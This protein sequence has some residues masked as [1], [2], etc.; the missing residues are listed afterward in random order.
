[1]K[2]NTSLAA[3]LA[4]V[5]IS[6]LHGFPMRYAPS[7][8]FSNFS[9]T[10]LVK[11]NGSPSGLSCS[12]GGMGGIGGGGGRAD[13]KQ[14]SYNKSEAFSCRIKSSITNEF[15]EAE[16][17]S[18]LRSD[19]KKDLNE[20]DQKITSAK[21]PTSSSF[22]FEY[23]EGEMRGRIEITGER[24]G[25]QYYSLKASLKESSEKKSE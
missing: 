11:K 3:F 23:E 19:V 14:V 13:P 22:Y 25:S 9:L 18:S 24:R 6:T 1:M 2:I 15:D 5:L 8:F 7:K 12:E 10:E 21:S 17:I 20:S 4:I 16:F